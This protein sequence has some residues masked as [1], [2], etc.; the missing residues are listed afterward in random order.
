MAIDPLGS[1]MSLQEPRAEPLVEPLM[2][3]SIINQQLEYNQDLRILTPGQVS[4]VA[5][6]ETVGKPFQYWDALD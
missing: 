5:L 6:T 4:E 2:Q 1:I 3:A